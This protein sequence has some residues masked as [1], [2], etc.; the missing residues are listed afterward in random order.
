MKKILATFGLMIV[1]LIGFVF[2]P[3]ANIAFAQSYRWTHPND[4]KVYIP[5][6]HRHTPMMRRAFAEW[7]RKTNGRIVFKYVSSKTSAD[8]EVRYFD[9]IRYCGETHNAI[10]CTVARGG[11]CTKDVCRF[12]HAYIDIADE[13]VNGRELTTK[14]EIYSTM[15]HEIGHAIGLGHNETNTLS[16]MSVS[17][18][19]SI[20]KQEIIKDDLKALAKL[21]NWR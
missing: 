1:F 8:I 17:P 20:L 19:R 6:K 21:Y 3:C 14:V 7:T 11:S 5:P 4:I 15:L 10:G 16:I 13:T 2:G 12:V 9:K 18:Y